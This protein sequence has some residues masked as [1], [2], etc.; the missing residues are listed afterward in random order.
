[1][2]APTNDPSNADETNSFYMDL[3]ESVRGVA[4]G[5]ML[6]VMGDF[7]ARVGNDVN[8]WKGVVGSHGIPE[9][10]ENGLKLLDFCS[11][12]NLLVTNTLFMHRDC[13]KFTWFHPGNTSGVGHMMDFIL[14]NR[15]F[16]SSILDSRVFRGT[17]LQS[18]HRLVVA[19][20]RVK[21]K[22]M[23]KKKKVVPHRYVKNIKSLSKNEC[24]EYE[25]CVRSVFE[26]CKFEEL[27]VSWMEFKVVLPVQEV[28]NIG[29]WVT[30]EVCR[31]SELKRKAWV[32]WMNDPGK[33]E[34]KVEYLRLKALSKKKVTEAKEKWWREQA[35]ELGERYEECL[36]AGMGGS[37][38]RNL[39]VLRSSQALHSSSAVLAKDGVTKLFTVEKKLERWR[40]HFEDLLNVVSHVE[41]S[42]ID[43][44]SSLPG[45]DLESLTDRPT[46]GEVRL[47]IRDLKNGKAPGE[48]GISAELLKI[49]GDTAVEW[50]TKLCV[51]IWDKEEIPKDWVRQVVIPLHKK[52]SRLVC[53]NYRGIS[54]LSV[55]GKVLCKVLQRRFVD[56]VDWC[57]RESQCGFRKGRSCI[58]HV[59]T[60]RMLVEKAREFQ[61]PLYFCFI[62]LKKAYDSVNRNALWMLL[63]KRYC[64]PEKFISILKVFHAGTTGVV[65]MNGWLFLQGF[66]C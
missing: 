37:L 65:R 35:Q 59:F 40:E 8:V 51:L 49:G 56:K 22:V 12:N 16:R 30:S 57:L 26:K 6:L 41:S 24:E 45:A 58:D 31:I 36:R 1:M 50:I 52:G 48:D 19:K 42:V 43:L 54:L 23:R 63:K 18:D 15:K 47:A 20:V 34:L 60:V 39:K 55:P 66:Y 25:K 14:V 62:D 29:D 3:Q 53:D 44:V 11:V 4:S 64:L 13:H 28:R 38:L 32:R 61:K 5:D 27:E 9:V 21:F 33:V 17:Y 46:E 2:Y 10:N 7:N